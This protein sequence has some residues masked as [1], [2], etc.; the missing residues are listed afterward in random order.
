MLQRINNLHP[1]FLDF[2]V[3]N[4]LVKQGAQA[5]FVLKKKKNLLKTLNS[6]D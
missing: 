2:G 4:L 3:S 1:L 6:Y 5:S